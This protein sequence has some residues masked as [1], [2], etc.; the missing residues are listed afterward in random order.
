MTVNDELSI[1]YTALPTLARFHKDDSNLYRG[2]MGN[3]RSGKSTGMCM[4]IM[5]RAIRQRPYHGVR[6][7]R[8]AVI[9]NTYRELA[10]T[11]L[12][13]WLMWFDE[14]YFGPF[15]YGTM[16]HIVNIPSPMHDGTEIELEVLFRALDRPADIKKLLS[17]E[18]TGGWINEAREVP[19]GVADTLGDRCGQYPSKRE[20]GCTWYGVIMDTNPPDSDHWWYKLFEET[21]PATWSLYRQ[22]GAIIEVDGEFVVNPEGENFANLNEGAKYYL[23]RIPGKDHQYVR[24]YYC[25]EYGFV[26]EGKPVYPEYTDGLHCWKEPLEAIPGATIYIGIDFGLTPAA[27][28]A[29][30]T[31]QGRWHWFDELVT[32]DMGA[33]RFGELLKA[34]MLGE[35]KD[36]QFD[37]YGDPAG[38]QRSQTDERTPF[39]ILNTMGIPAKPAPS[40]DMTL[41]REAVAVPLSRIIDGKPGLII[42]PT[43]KTLRKGMQG[44]YSYK[45]MQIAGETE[46]YHD[47]P[48]KNKYSHVCEAGQYLM[49]GAGEGRML[50]KG[51]EPVLTMHFGREHRLPSQD[52]G[53]MR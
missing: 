51:D 39:Q 19:R 53:W 37:I 1:T 42:S 30:K 22:P 48:D 49:L 13:T 31:V 6:K 12:K 15:N 16:S 38:D 33:V 28:F 43:C 8:W 32:E 40:N 36:F 11:T 50:I 45:R 5:S 4:E 20:G 2:V 52:G 3:V 23:D 17:M 47:K 14:A 7:S 34:K 35:Y 10:D 25:G 27:V 26:L 44:G 29:Q 24:V 41:R 9:R 18:V 46:R 21:R